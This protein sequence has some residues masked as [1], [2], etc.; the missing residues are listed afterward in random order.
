MTTTAVKTAAV[1]APG[2]RALKP[3]KYNRRETIAAYLFISPW[4]IGFLI[5]TLG[6]MIY[7]LVISFSHYQLATNTSRPAGFS[8]YQA[9]LEDPKVLTSLGNTLF[10]AVLAVPGCRGQ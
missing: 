4:I 8:N 5:F 9:L 2:S 1:S 10:Y 3:R 7:S 6:A